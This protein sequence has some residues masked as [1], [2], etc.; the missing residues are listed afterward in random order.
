VGTTSTWHAE[1][2]A[3]PLGWEDGNDDTEDEEEFAEVEERVYRQ[4]GEEW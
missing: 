3:L 2:E 4:M 1:S